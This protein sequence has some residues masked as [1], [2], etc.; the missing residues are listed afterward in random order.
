MH[1]DYPHFDFSKPY[2]PQAV[3]KVDTEIAS[4]LAKGKPQ[5]RKIGALLGGMAKNQ[6]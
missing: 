2:E 6:K 4:P 1:G 3:P 5:P